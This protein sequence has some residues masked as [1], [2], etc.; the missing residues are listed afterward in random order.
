MHDLFMFYFKKH[1][2]KFLVIFMIS[3]ITI[4]LASLEVI[5][6]NSL[7]NSLTNNSNTF[8]DLAL[9]LVYITI[10]LLNIICLQYLIPR[11]S[12][13]ITKNLRKR[14]V[15]SG[16]SADYS[17]IQSYKTGDLINRHDTNASLVGD[18]ITRFISKLT[19]ILSFTLLIIMLYSEINKI[20][21]LPIMLNIFLLFFVN[22]TSKKIPKIMNE[23]HV[24]K[25][26]SN[27]FFQCIIQN[28]ITI[29]AYGLEGYA[30]K[31]FKKY[32]LRLLSMKKKM[33]KKDFLIEIMEEICISINTCLIPIV[34]IILVYFNR[35][36]LG[37]VAASLIISPKIS[38]FYKMVSSLVIDY[39]KTV[40]LGSVISCM[41]KFKKHNKISIVNDSAK[42]SGIYADYITFKHIKNKNIFENLS[43]YALKGQITVIKG[44][45]GIGK[46]T[47]LGL[48]TGRYSPKSGQIYY[49]QVKQDSSNNS[50]LLRIALMNP[51]PY[52]FNLS[53]IQNL[54]LTSNFSTRHIKDFL[55]KFDNDFKTNFRS[56]CNSKLGESGKLISAGQRQLLS[57][58]QLLLIDP[59]VFILDEPASNLDKEVLPLLLDNLKK[60]KKDKTII[61]ATHSNEI[62]GIA[63]KVY[64]LNKACIREEHKG[65]YEF[66][67]K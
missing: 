7:V 14:I 62:I 37:L 31:N 51:E 59:H 52:F 43:F 49:N 40:P 1:L 60:I 2:S 23:I 20:I 61:I 15:A 9:V 48:L 41:I 8:N 54:K 67:I 33:I 57:Y 29:K 3:I 4:P 16:I 11:L 63:D 12:I 5:V 55:N 66:S 30:Q 56:I 32:Q 42:E 26:K 65:N 10:S 21:V 17:Y 36:E 35:A 25:G 46:S 53:I 28:I 22:R 39:K 58:I 44:K 38:G 45:S 47:L 34:S 13:E 50:E 18:F 6:I 27:N 19:S 64:N 24:Q